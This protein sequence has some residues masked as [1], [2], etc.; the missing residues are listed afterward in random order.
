LF[1]LD[2]K[3]ITSLDEL[4]DGHGYVCSST[5]AFR[6]LGYDKIHNPLWITQFRA[7]IK[8]LGEMGPDEASS[9]LKDIAPR[10]IWVFR[11]GPRPR[12][13]VRA[14]LNR[15]TARSFEQ[16]LSDLADQIRETGPIKTI[17]SLS[18]K[19]VCSS[20]YILLYK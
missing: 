2:G 17:Y 6:R 11:A 3:P 9:S 12:T 8:G 18:G 4:T 15:R 10:M 14:L 13:H 16:L 7:T 1:T 20:T 19:Q 5:T